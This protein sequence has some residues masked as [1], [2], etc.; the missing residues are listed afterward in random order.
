MPRPFYLPVN[1]T[2]GQVNTPQEEEREKNQCSPWGSFTTCQA[3]NQ[4]CHLYASSERPELKQ[5]PAISFGASAGGSPKHHTSRVP[6]SPSSAPKA[7]SVPTS[8]RFW[9]QTPSPTGMLSSG[10][11]P[12]RPRHFPRIPVSPTVPPVG[13]RKQPQHK[14]P[15]WGELPKHCKMHP[16][17]FGE[18]NY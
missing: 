2:F 8:H 15:A 4:W 6:P 13:L 14:S 11:R 1:H 18:G 9:G 7:T 10:N 5:G 3:Q 12:Q 17:G 16:R